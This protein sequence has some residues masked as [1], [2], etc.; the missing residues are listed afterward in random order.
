MNRVSKRIKKNKEVFQ[1]L[2]GDEYWEKRLAEM[3]VTG[4]K[5]LDATCDELGRMLAETLMVMDREEIAGED[6]RPSNQDLQKWG[7]QKGSVY[8]GDQKVKVNHPRL[9]ENGKEKP[10][11]LYERLKSPKEFSEEMLAN[12]LRGLSGRK[13]KETVK[14]LAGGFGISASSISK[15]FIEASYAK[16]SQ[17]LDRDLSEYKTFVIFLDTVHRGGSAFTVALGIDVKGKKRALGL[18]EGATENRDVAGSL[19]SDLESRGLNLNEDIIFV[20][21]GG[22][23]II[24]ALKDRFKKKLLHQRC[25]IHKDR[26]IQSH[27]PKKYRKQAHRRFRDAIDLTSYEDAKQALENLRKWLAGINESSAR[28]LDEAMEE[29][30]TL[31][32][33]KVPELLRKT[34]HS[35]NCIESM[36]STVRHCEKNLKRYRSSRMSQRWLASVL[37]Y[38][39]S[40]FRTVKGYNQIPWVIQKINVLRK[41]EPGKKPADRSSGEPSNLQ[42][43]EPVSV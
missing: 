28:S 16:L 11:R 27:L 21:D 19:L 20:T 14:E 8:I 36:F 7:F 2:G 17:F 42:N 9:R 15:R 6:Y 31:H 29:L 24:R 37:I 35:T 3:I 23:G 18:W 30:L 32:R 4:K 34:L 1:A 43:M 5:A 10:S 33:L 39:E 22:G 41:E 25:T 40:N 13:Y 26:N 38:A 12:A